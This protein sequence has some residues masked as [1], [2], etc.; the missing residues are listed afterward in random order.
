ME[1]ERGGGERARK[2]RQVP[3]AGK[4]DRGARPP[5]VE[6]AAAAQAKGCVCVGG[7][8]CGVETPLTG[9]SWRKR[10]QQA[11]TVGLQSLSGASKR[12]RAP[13]QAKWRGGR[14]LEREN[15]ALAANSSQAKAILF[16]RAK[17]SQV[18]PKGPTSCTVPATVMQPPPT[19]QVRP[20]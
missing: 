11:R 19:P 14:D 4:L 18:F 10:A 7:E 1:R 2:I 12:E 5:P 17:L 15:A 6:K 9:A 16:P 3:P 20:H 8:A 13:G